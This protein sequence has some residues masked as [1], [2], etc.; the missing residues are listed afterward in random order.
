MF[1]INDIHLTGDEVEYDYTGLLY[2]CIFI[3]KVKTKNIV[4]NTKQF[5]FGTLPYIYI[6]GT[7]IRWTKTSKTK[8][9]HN[10][11]LKIIGVQKEYKQ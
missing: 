11:S 3:G 8:K 5:N 1:S 10:T 6:Y 7:I 2:I 9:K 4:S